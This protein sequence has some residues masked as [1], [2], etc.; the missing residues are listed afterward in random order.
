V[1]TVFRSVAGAVPEACADFS[2]RP[3]VLATGG[4]RGITAETLRELARP[5]NVL[6]LTGRSPLVDEAEPL[7]RLHRRRAGPPA[8]HRRGAQRRREADAGRDPA[9]DRRR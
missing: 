9:Q 5:G 2:R 3:V 7:G 1:R 8:L 6:V 4:A